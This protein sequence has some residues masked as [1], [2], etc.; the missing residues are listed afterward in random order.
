MEREKLSHLMY[1]RYVDDVRL[2]LP[3]LNKGWYWDGENFSFSQER[4]LQDLEGSDSD[5]HRTTLEV[6]KAMTSVIDFLNFTGED[7][8]MF[9]DGRL[10]TLDTAI[11]M[12][13]GSIMYS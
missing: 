2:V 3:V 6:T 7:G 12:E 5:E 10:P 11:W 9:P 13:E 4:K 8:S 1:L